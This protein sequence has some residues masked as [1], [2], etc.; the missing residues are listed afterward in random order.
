MYVEKQFALQNVHTVG[1]VPGQI[2]VR[3]QKGLLGDDPSVKLISYKV[4]DRFDKEIRSKLLETNN[5]YIIILYVFSP[6]LPGFEYRVKL[7]YNVEVNSKGIFFYLLRIPLNEDSPIP[8]KTSSVELR[9]PEG[10]K[11]S[12]VEYKDNS[13][14]LT[15]TSAKWIVTP[16]SPSSIVFEYTKLPFPQTSVRSGILFWFSINLLL[17]I[18]LAIEILLEMRRLR[19]NN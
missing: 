2:E 3:I 9:I 4:Y 1:I 16:N 7:N 10:Y 5:E 8:V 18:I 19:K 17:F 6:L 13:T 11:L 15:K 12:Y 14:I